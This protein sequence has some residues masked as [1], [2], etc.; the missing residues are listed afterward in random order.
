MA[1]KSD[2]YT[3]KKITSSTIMA[4]NFWLLK[5]LQGGFDQRDL[6]IDFKA[7]L[8]EQDVEAL[9]DCILNK[10]IKLRRKAICIFALLKG[11]PKKYISECLCIHRSTIEEF[12]NRYKSGGLE[13][14]LKHNSQNK[15]KK[16][17]NPSYKKAVFS[18]L[19]SPP[20]CHGFNRTTWKI[21][22]L[23][24]VMTKRDLPIN[25]RIAVRLTFF[26]MK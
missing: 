16:Y 1:V 8:P 20:S 4:W 26:K 7:L 10:P 14:L 15:I 2:K 13:R 11:I 6:T 25:K 3:T 12:I 5:I 18:I 21:S 24:E 19:H 9:Y 17:E 22:D 23:Q